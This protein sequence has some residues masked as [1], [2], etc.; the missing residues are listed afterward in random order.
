MTSKRKSTDPP[1]PLYTKATGLCFRPER[2]SCGFRTFRVQRR[3]QAVRQRY[4]ADKRHSSIPTSFHPNRSL[5]H[6]LGVWLSFFGFP[7]PFV[8]LSAKA[9]DNL[10]G[11]RTK[12][13]WT[14]MTIGVSYFQPAAP[15][16]PRSGPKPF[17]EPLRLSPNRLNINFIVLIYRFYSIFPTIYV[18]FV[19]Q[20]RDAPCMERSKEE[21]FYN[22]HL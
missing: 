4:R 5:D 8:L 9:A 20:K 1:I 16:P 13:L 3:Q 12:S 17:P 14:L 21:L 18:I 11:S 22:Q 19:G 7:S 15:I 10:H 2:R 6:R